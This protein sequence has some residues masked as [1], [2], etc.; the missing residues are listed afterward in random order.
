MISA[1]SPA[2]VGAMISLPSLMAVSAVLQ[3][4]LQQPL[5]DAHGEASC[6]S[7]VLPNAHA[8]GRHGNVSMPSCRTVQV[9]ELAFGR[10]AMIAIRERGLNAVSGATELGIL[11][12]DLHSLGPIDWE[13]CG[14]E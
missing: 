13:R 11:G 10:I 8:Q 9:C 6:R 14:Q 3:S 5:Q 2:W 4:H 7:H 12:K 1:R